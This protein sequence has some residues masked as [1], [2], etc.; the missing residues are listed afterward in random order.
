M[1]AITGTL[2]AFLLTG[3]YLLVW[4]I[5]RLWHPR[6]TQRRQA[7]FELFLLECCLYIPPTSFALYGM[8][9]LPDFHHVLGLMNIVYLLLALFLWTATYG[10]WADN[11][12]DDHA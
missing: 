1:N 3:G 6:K 11:S 2:F 10:V 5:Y 9:R 12:P 7:L 4:P 8:F